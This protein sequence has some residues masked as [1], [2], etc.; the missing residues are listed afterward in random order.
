M[1]H[2]PT[3]TKNL[4]LS[5]LLLLLT[6]PSPTTEECTRASLLSTTNTYILAQT[7]GQLTP[8][9][10]T[11]P[12]TTTNFTYVENNKA[13]A[14]KHSIL[15]Q[16]L[17]TDLNRSTADTL[18]CASYTLLISSSG[19]KTV[20]HIHAKIRHVTTTTTTGSGEENR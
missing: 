15:T 9:T 11:L 3:L 20:R 5:T 19:S 1:Y 10:L 12:P 14:I 7:T 4:L 17:K 16:P 8:L 18:A 2:H 6:L 13:A